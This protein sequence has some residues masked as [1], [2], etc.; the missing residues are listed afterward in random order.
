[1]TRFAL[2][3][4]VI[5]LASALFLSCQKTE[6]DRFLKIGLPEEPRSLNLWLGTDANSR[7]IL[8][9][10]YQPLYNRH[11]ETLEIIPWLAAEDPEINQEDLTYTIKLRE[12]KWSDGTDFTSD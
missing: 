9:Q 7:K 2:T 10:I 6:E 12:A 5:V 3:A 11:P 8:T 4:M 1:M